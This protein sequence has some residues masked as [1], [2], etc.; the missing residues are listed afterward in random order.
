[1]RFRSPLAGTIARLENLQAILPPSRSDDLA[2]AITVLIESTL[3]AERDWPTGSPL[4]N[5]IMGAH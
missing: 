3:K 2:C 4:W 1:M 5:P